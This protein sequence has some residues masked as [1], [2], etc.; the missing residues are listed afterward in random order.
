MAKMVSTDALARLADALDARMKEAI[1][2][3]EERARLA[4]G[5][6][7][8]AIDEVEDMLGGKVIVYLTQ[9]EFNALTEEE[10]NDDT[11]A[12]FIIDAEEYN[13]WVGTSEELNI[14]PNKDP[15]TI[16]FEVDDGIVNDRNTVVPLTIRDGVLQLTTDKY[17]K[18]ENIVSGTRIEFPAV[19]MNEYV[20]IHL[21]FN[22][23]TDLNLEFP[24]NCKWR[25]DPNILAGKAYE[26]VCKY[27]TMLW[28]VNII[29][30]S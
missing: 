25:V 27:N 16:Y 12:Y 13:I 20:E 1:L 6:L 23:L 9:A 26:I 18:V 3:E 28:L 15:N 8:E 30:Y 7:Q 14:I 11:K 29:V 19:N 2:A 4:E 24:E 5:E 17:Q 21:F 22:S 10:K